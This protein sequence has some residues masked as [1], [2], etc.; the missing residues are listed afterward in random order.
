MIRFTKPS[1]KLTE[2][3][4]K[5][6]QQPSFCV[7][8]REFQEL[9]RMV[10][11]R[12]RTLSAPNS[13]I[14]VQFNNPGQC[15]NFRLKLQKY[16]PRMKLNVCIWLCL[17]FRWISVLA[18]PWSDHFYRRRVMSISSACCQTNHSIILLIA[19]HFFDLIAYKHCNG[20]I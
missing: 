4:T 1:T 5:Q 6:E 8:R 11:C 17:N 3:F 19:W 16:T 10:K 20:Q 12:Y 7:L 15:L 14:K 2:L 9:G 18:T 13:Q